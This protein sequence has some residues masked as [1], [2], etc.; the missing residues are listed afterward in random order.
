MRYFTSVIREHVTVDNVAWFVQ[1][2]YAGCTPSLVEED[3]TFSQQ[4]HQ[5]HRQKASVFNNDAAR[6]LPGFLLQVYL[7]S[8]LRTT[9]E[10]HISQG[11]SNK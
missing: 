3:L 9:T 7:G 10:S 8:S 5:V 11:V 2:I 1:A 6:V 4:F